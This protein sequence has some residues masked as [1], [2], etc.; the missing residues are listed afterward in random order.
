MILY[1]G[2]MR[3]ATGVEQLTDNQWEEGG[4]AWQPQMGVMLVKAAGAR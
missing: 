2:W 4:P 3:D 1:G